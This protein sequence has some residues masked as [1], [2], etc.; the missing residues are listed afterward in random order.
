MVNIALK[1]QIGECC[2]TVENG[3]RVYDQIYA[4]LSAK[5]QVQLDFAGV[6]IAAPPFL[7]VAIGQLLRDLDSETPD[8]YLKFKNLP[9]VSKPILRRVIENAKHYYSD[10]AYRAAVEAVLAKREEDFDAD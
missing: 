7:S 10:P 4:L 9:S 8:T 3:Q 2:I 5:Q 1:E 6:Q